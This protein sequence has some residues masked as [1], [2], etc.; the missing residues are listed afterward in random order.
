MIQ[1]IRHTLLLITFTCLINFAH[2]AQW[3]LEPGSTL[4]FAGEAQGDAFA[5]E[6]KRFNAQIWFDPDAFESSRFAVEVDLRSV[7]SQN[8]ERDEMLAD[9]AFFNSASEPTASYVASSFSALKDGRFR[10]M[11]SLTLRGV[12]LEVPLDFSWTSDAAGAT[13]IGEASLDRT[14]FKVGAGEWAD[15]DAI[16]HDVRVTTTLKLKAAP[17]AGTP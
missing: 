6:F 12:T 15:A 7:D 1:T 8:S 4:G 17:P 14:A 3:N 5:G 16:A 13:L 10:A 11:G 9:A 2:A